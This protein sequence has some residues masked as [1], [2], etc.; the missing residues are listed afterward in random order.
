[1]ELSTV[2]RTTGAVREF[3]GEPVSREVLHA[4]LDDA[5][6]APSGGNRQGW[7]VA[8]VE[9]PD[10]RR[11]LASLCAPVWGEYMAQTV[12]GETPFSVVQ[13]TVVDLA[14]AAADPPAN[15]ML[16]DLADAPA[17]LVVAVDL[18]AL[19]VMDKDLDRPSVVGGGSIYPFCQN[20]MLAA[21]N[22]GLGGVMTTFLSRAEERAAPLL[23]LPEGHAIVAMVV[24]GIPVRQPTK[25]RRNAV[26]E[27]TTVD[28][29]GGEAF[30]VPSA[31]TATPNS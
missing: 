24:L 15:P 19:A 11:Q 3:T 13:P 9:D 20:L 2:M 16:D 29:F 22:H 17:V 23:G 14:A 30:S 28:R 6:F 8:V 5:R 12:A 10:L 18:S 27:F 7:K 1:M 26:E 21:R 25:L 31:P 4:V